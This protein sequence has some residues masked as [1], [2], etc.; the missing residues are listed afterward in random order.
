MKKIKHINKNTD[1]LRNRKWLPFVILLVLTLAAE[2]AVFN[3][4][5]CKS[6]LYSERTLFEDITAEGG[7]LVESDGTVYVA[8]DGTLTLTVE[9][10]NMEVHNLF[11]ALD[12]SEHEPVYYTVSVCDEGNYYAF[13]MPQQVLMPDM[14]QTY[15]TSLYPAGEVLKLSIQLMVPSGS[16]VGVHG[17]GVN[18][19]VPFAFSIGRMVVIYAFLALLYFLAGVGAGRIRASVCQKDVKQDAVTAVV[20]LL[21]IGLAW[22]LAHV[23]PVCIEAPWPHHRQYQELAEALAEGRVYLAAEPSEELLAVENPYDTIYLQANGI[24]YQ[25]DYAFYEGKYYVYFG[26]VPELLLYLPCY[27]LTGH[28]L[29]NYAAVFLFYSGFTAAV[30]ALYREIVKRWF[31][32]TPYFLYLMAG[33]LTVLCGNYLFV[34]AR[35]DLY[36]APIMAAN[37]FTAAGLWLWIKG[38]F[39]K[40][41]RIRR[42]AYLTG[43]LCMALV[44]GCRPQMLLFSILAIPLFWDEVIHKRELFG[45]KG[46]ADTVCICMPYVLVA[47]GIMYYNAVRFGSP[48]DFGATYSLTSNDMTKRSFNVQQM[49]L[50]L[51][52]YFLQPPQLSS[53]FPFV[54]GIQVSSQSYMGRLNAEYTYGGMLVS[55]AML[56]ILVFAGRGRSMLKRK[57]LWAFAAANAVIAVV[58]GIVDVTGAGIL[59]RYTVDMIWGLMAAAVLVL[60][61]LWEQCEAAGA[62][63]GLV[64]FLAAVCVLQALYGVGVVFGNGDLSVNVRGTN[65]ELYYYLKGLF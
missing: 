57:G 10:V 37:M 45:K 18:A 65:P 35:P 28:H 7:T 27:L 8:E 46:L 59:Q 13:P 42:A 2:T 21:L 24:S 15:Y 61:A 64:L 60:F 30:F 50:G 26:I 38:K 33:V 19:R 3:F 5:A 55:N 20:V 48:F 49:L 32:K 23:N 25:A 40:S 58:L 11:L 29:P 16:V 62:H 17:I 6:L 44:A 52:H 36:D 56:W 43:S 41:V 9:N 4:S 34:I 39:A 51:W 22:K 14:P 12:F 54:Q 53:D 47:A 63:R 31:A 1:I